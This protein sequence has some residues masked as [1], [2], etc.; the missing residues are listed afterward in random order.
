MVE[1]GKQEGRKKIGDLEG[2]IG[3]LRNRL[4][5]AVT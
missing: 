3:T 4:G 5:L 1:S 2:K